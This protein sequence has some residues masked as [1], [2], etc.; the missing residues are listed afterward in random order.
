MFNNKEV[1]AI[2]EGYVARINGLI[3]EIRTAANNKEC[4]MFAGH[5]MMAASAGLHSAM[6]YFKKTANRFRGSTTEP[7]I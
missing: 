4:P 7:K 6:N 2:C 3:T 5:E 1:A